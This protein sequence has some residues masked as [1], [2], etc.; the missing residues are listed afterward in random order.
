MQGFRTGSAISALLR[1]IPRT[2]S[3]EK[4]KMDRPVFGRK[5]QARP[6]AA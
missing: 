4:H 2:Y 1:L 3:G 5:A 6:P